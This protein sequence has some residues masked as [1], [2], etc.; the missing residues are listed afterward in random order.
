MKSSARNIL[1]EL[2]I[3]LIVSAVNGGFMTLALMYARSHGYSLWIAMPLVFV[4]GIIFSVLVSVIRA[5]L[6]S[7]SAD[8]TDRE[9]NRKFN[10]AMG[11]DSD[12]CLLG[13]GD[14]GHVYEVHIN[15]HLEETKVSEK[16]RPE[17]C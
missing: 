1:R 17:L 15:T 16:S 12:K 3:F 2:G 8:V 6:D 11:F 9:Y 13:T 4:G 14:L 7:K 5:R 10:A